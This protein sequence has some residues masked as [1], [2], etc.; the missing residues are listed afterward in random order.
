MSLHELQRMVSSGDLPSLLLLHGDEP[1]FL[2]RGIRLIREAVVPGDFSDFNFNQLDGRSLKAAELIEQARTFPVFAPRRLLHVR[3]FDQVAAEQLDRLLDYLDHP[4]EETVLMMTAGK[5]DGRRK[6]FQRLRKVGKI[7]E[8]KKIYEN[9]LPTQV[10]EMASARGVTLT[11]EALRLFCT[12][13]GTNLV[14]VDGELEKLVSYVGDRTLIEAADIT[15]IVSDTRVES[16]F[17][18]TEAIGKGDADRALRLV[19]RLLD[20]GQ[21]PLM[22]LTMIVRHFRQMWRIRSLQ[23]RNL[24]ARELASQVGINPYFLKDLAAQARSFDENRY[25]PAFELFLVTDLALKSS[26]AEPVAHL[27]QLILGVAG[28][29]V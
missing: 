5:I 8:F 9:Q 1:F 13:V 17:A 7:F 26:G 15:A 14:E 23:A 29:T 4:V 27:E 11:G 16:V 21:A 25:A 28:Q 19:H 3:S 22:I 12:R 2:E 24:P 6:F 20:D 18:L 10:R